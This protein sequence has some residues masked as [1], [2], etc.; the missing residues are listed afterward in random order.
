MTL[1]LNINL[2]EINLLHRAT[3]IMFG[4]LVWLVW[5]VFGQIYKQFTIVRYYMNSSWILTGQDSLR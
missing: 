1:T 2:S 5:K 4:W 3:Y